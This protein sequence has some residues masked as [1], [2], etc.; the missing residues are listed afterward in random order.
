MRTSGRGITARGVV[1]PGSIGHR[2]KNTTAIS[3]QG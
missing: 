3:D 1:A 2:D